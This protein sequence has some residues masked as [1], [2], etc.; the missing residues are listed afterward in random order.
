MIR[1]LTLVCL[2]G[3][4]DLSALECFSIE[5]SHYH[6]FIQIQL[7]NKAG[8]Q[9]KLIDQWGEVWLHSNPKRAEKKFRGRC[10]LTRGGLWECAPDT[11][12]TAYFEFFGKKINYLALNKRRNFGYIE[13][14][15]I[16]GI[17]FRIYNGQCI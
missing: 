17:K 3:I 1:L 12:G 14:V 5:K 4:G 13:F 11:I 9:V 7:K 16:T 8:S 2:L 6:P 15:N 10:R